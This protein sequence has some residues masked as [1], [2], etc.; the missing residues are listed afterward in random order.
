MNC[1]AETMSKNYKHDVWGSGKRRRINSPDY[2]QEPRKWN[3]KAKKEGYRYRV[4]SSSM[5]DNFE[6]H[7]DVISQLP[8]LWSLIKQTPWLDWLLLTKR[9]HRIAQSLPPDWGSGYHNVWMGVS[10][11]NEDYLHRIDA[12]RQ[13]PATVR[14]VSYEPALGPIAH[15]ANLTD[16]DWLIYGGESGTPH[17]KDNDQWAIDIMKLCN[18]QPATSFYYKQSSGHVQAA[19]DKLNGKYIQKYPTRLRVP[20]PTGI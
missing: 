16:I 11:E 17:R 9:D 2:W 3:R 4:F 14:F 18:Q 6:D 13:I 19:N 8:D 15:K 7:P 20:I 1:Y 12:L 5:C 10:V